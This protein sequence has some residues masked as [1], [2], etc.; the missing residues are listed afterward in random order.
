MRFVLGF[1]GGLIRTLLDI[2]LIL[3]GMVLCCRI[4]EMSEN[5]KKES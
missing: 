2:G 3:V 4:E 1:I 5:Q